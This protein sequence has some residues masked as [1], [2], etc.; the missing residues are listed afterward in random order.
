M[1]TRGGPYTKCQKC[2]RSK[3]TVINPQKKV[4]ECFKWATIAALH[5]E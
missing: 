3:K 5:H 4:E 2:L 1:L